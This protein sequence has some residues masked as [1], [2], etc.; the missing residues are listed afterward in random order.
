[1]YIATQ[2][3]CSTYQRG[4]YCLFLLKGHFRNLD[5]ENERG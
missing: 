5:V 2:I 3:A 4:R 1:M